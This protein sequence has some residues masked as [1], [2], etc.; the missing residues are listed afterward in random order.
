MCSFKFPLVLNQ[1]SHNWHLNFFFE[2]TTTLCAIRPENEEKTMNIRNMLRSQDQFIESTNFEHCRNVFHK[3]YI[4]LRHPIDELFCELLSF[5]LNQ[6][7]F[8]ISNTGKASCTLLVHIWTYLK[9]LTPPFC[10]LAY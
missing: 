2:C 6:T 4:L 5:L 8:Y 1:T 9:V 3:W 7:L 10:S